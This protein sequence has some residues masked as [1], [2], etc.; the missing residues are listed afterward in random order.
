MHAANPY[1]SPESSS[2][3]VTDTG[4]RPIRPPYMWSGILLVIGVC[5]L[6]LLNG[7]FFT[8]TLVFLGL[9]VL[10]TILWA[11]VLV[12]ARQNDY[13]RLALY[14]IFGHLVLIVFFATGLP[15]YHRRQQRFNN[16]RNELRQG[17]FG[18]PVDP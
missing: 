15:E 12:R 7:Q 11:P 13:R 1:Q 5:F 3:D 14:V 10:S 9:V 6:L 8:N 2:H 18:Q 4:A 17:G 16:M